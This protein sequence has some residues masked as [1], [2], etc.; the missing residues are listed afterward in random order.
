[1]TSTDS[2][3]SRPTAEYLLVQQREERMED[4]EDWMT[5]GAFK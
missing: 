1:M 3:A 2:G 4:F 5:S